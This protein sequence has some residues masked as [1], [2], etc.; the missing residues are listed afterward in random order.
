VLQKQ[1]DQAIK[2]RD[3]AQA[4][5]LISQQVLREMQAQESEVVKELQEENFELKDKLDRTEFIIQY[6]EEIWTCLERE[7]RKVVTKDSDL[8]K[9]CE[10]KTRILT[11]CLA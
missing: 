1:L 4:E 3:R 9:K 2:D 7:I 11:D 6:K 10:Q 5:S 8:L